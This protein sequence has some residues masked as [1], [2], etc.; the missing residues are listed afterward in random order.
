MKRVLLLALLVGCVKMED[1]IETGPEVHVRVRPMSSTSVTDEETNPTITLRTTQTMYE[2]T[3]DIETDDGERNREGSFDRF[4]VTMVEGTVSVPGVQL[5]A[6]VFEKE[7]ESTNTFTGKTMVVIPGT[8]KG[9]AMTITAV[10]FDSRGLS[11]N[12]LAF[13][14]ALR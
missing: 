10:G 1:T 13:D 3:I 5:P 8:A 11:S 4:D 6:L 9:Q 7:N 12:Q 2:L 14:V